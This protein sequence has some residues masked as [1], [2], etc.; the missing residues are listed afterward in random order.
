MKEDFARTAAVVRKNASELKLCKAKL[1]LLEKAL[2]ALNIEVIIRETMVDFGT[3][4]CLN[5]KV[6]KNG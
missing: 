1:V 5:V 2:N 4:R 3:K 6:T